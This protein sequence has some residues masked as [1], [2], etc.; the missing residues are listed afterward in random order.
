[1]VA[2]FLGETSSFHGVV[3]S[4]TDG[5][6][7]VAMKDGFRATLK[8]NSDI[9]EGNDVMVTIRPEAVSTTAQRPD[10]EENVVAGVVD[11]VSYL[12]AHVVYIIRVDGSGA[13]IKSNEPIP[14][15][16]PSFAQGDRV[17][18][19]WDIDHVVYVRA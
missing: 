8:H 16:E 1:M 9:A 11:F 13:I 18:A 5:V 12:G 17:F 6:A 15:G 19:Y 7:H 3:E 2:T 4:D 10:Q 14:S